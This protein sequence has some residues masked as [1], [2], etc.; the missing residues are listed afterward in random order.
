MVLP[1]SKQNNVFQ[2]FEAK[3]PGGGDAAAAHW[4]PATEQFRGRIKRMRDYIIENI[5]KRL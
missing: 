3:P 1:I 5:I 2:T 4:S